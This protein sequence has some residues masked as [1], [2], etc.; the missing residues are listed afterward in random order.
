ML[1][2]AM[3]ETAYSVM[4]RRQRK[5]LTKRGWEVAKRYKLNDPEFPR[6]ACVRL[7]GRYLD[8]LKTVTNYARAEGM[9]FSVVGVARTG[10]GIVCVRQ[11]GGS[12]GHYSFF[13]RRD[14]RRNIQIDSTEKTST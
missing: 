14:L 4:R 2:Y 1:G 8:T 3:T 12:Q 7:S 13:H 11:I 5:A 6:H 10:S 9:F